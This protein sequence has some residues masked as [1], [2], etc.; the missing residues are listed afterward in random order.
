[1]PSTGDFPLI[2][3]HRGSS[4][5]AP[6]NTLAAFRRAI[7]DRAE[8]VESDVR[9]TQDGEAVVFHD[10]TLKRTGQRTE[11]ILAMRAEELAAVDIGSWFNLKRP[12]RADLDFEKEKVAT[13]AEVL[14]VLRGFSGLIYV[15]LK[16]DPGKVE[17]LCEA[18]CSVIENSHLLP[19]MIVKSF[20]LS[21]IP[22][23][24]RLCP[25]V[26]TAALFDVRPMTA[27]RKE[28]RIIQAAKVAGAHQLSVHYSL[29]TKGLMRL[30][31]RENMPATVWTVDNPRWVKKGAE[32]GLKA[33]ITNDPALLLKEKNRAES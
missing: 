12:A 32:L 15:E 4:A 20:E 2:I 14:E 11:A 31:V 1:M 18:V 30:A 13:L 25:N 22:Y 9:L 17:A 10:A 29:A 8:G 21:A 28:S 27:L 19:Q 16:C 6:E 3:A 5:H 23:I 24:R 7:A 33:I 26:Q